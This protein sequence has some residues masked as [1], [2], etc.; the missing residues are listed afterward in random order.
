MAASSYYSAVQKAYIAYYGRPADIGGL[1]YWADRLNAAGGNLSA[2]I[3]AF[4][5]SAEAQDLYGDM[6][7]AA[8]VNTIYNQIFGRD[9]DTT[10]LN[11]YVQRLGNG[12]FTLVDVAQRIIDGATGSDATIVANKL[13]AAQS[14]TDAFDTTAEIVAY[15]G[16]NANEIA[17]DWLNDVGATSASL[18]AAQADLSDAIT[19]MIR[20]GIQGSEHD[21]TP[22]IDHLVGTNDND[23]FNAFTTDPATGA[24]ASTLS[25]YD[26]IDG[27]RGDFDTL[28]IY[29][30]Q[31]ANDVQHGSTTNVEVIN[32]YGYDVEGVDGFEVWKD[33]SDAQLKLYVGQEILGEDW[34][35]E[36]N[37]LANFMANYYENDGSDAVDI[38]YA[39]DVL[40]DYLGEDYVWAGEDGFWGGQITSRQVELANEVRDQMAEVITDAFN[41][42]LQTTYEFSLSQG[43]AWSEGFESY[44]IDGEGYGEEFIS[45]ASLNLALNAALA[46]ANEYV[47]ELQ[48]GEDSAWMTMFNVIDDLNPLQLY[49]DQGGDYGIDASKF[50][51]ATE[52]NLVGNWADIE[53]I[54]TAAVKISD[55]FVGE[56]GPFDNNNYGIIYLMTT[57]LQVSLLPT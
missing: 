18:T 23:T 3:Q 19:Q 30:L 9:A 10:G 20:T 52:I 49:A 38:S 35:T 2:I 43:I 22:G 8:A 1:T 13:V 5:T 32:F 17:R 26:T 41:S 31:G 6:S 42:S 15:D 7:Y 29:S 34:Y 25:L 27:G 56:D 33:L 39:V 51:G 16:V 53:H 50:I 11:W 24:T 55:V 40:N 54:T 21:L 45:E 47:N 44:Y 4:G 36:G 57:Y 28:N 12:T 14:F 48:D 37:D 46:A